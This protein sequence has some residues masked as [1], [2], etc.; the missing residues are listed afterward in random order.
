[1]AAGC[2]RPHFRAFR[3]SRFND[4]RASLPTAILPKNSGGSTSTVAAKNKGLPILGVLLLLGAHASLSLWSSARE[5]ATFDEVVHI[6]A[7]YTHLVLG[8]YRLAPVAA[9]LSKLLAA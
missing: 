1:M 8:D 4:R 6:G 2:T 5:S 7:G 3:S 9:P